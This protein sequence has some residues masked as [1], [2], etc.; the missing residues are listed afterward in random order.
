LKQLIEDYFEVPVEIGQFTGTWRRLPPNNLTFLRDTGAYC[1]R[2][3]MGT[4]VGDEAYDQH[5]AITVRLGPM[6]FERY[7]EFLPGERASIEL[8]SWL[9]FYTNREFDFVI[10]LVLER[11]EVPRMQMG[12]GGAGASRLGLVSWVRNRALARDPDEATY[13]LT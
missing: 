11:E 13:R 6:S 3:G 10:Q 7:R 9:R 2:L 4:I 1:E 12:E 5:G 8:R